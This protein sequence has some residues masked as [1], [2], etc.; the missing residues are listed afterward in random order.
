MLISQDIKY[1]CTHTGLRNESRYIVDEKLRK[2]YRGSL[3][4]YYLMPCKSVLIITWLSYTF[5][6]SV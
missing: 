3:R 5:F 2:K 6:N 4:K 1:D